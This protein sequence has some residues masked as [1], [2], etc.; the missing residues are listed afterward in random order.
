M[1]KTVPSKQTEV[2]SFTNKT[3]QKNNQTEKKTLHTMN[4]K[5]LTNGIDQ[6]HGFIVWI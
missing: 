5:V 4:T 6:S 3:K 2:G 1:N